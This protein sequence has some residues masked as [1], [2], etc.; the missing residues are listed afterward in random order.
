[1]GIEQL[2]DAFKGNPQPLQAKVQQ[3]QQGQPPGA[4]PPDLEEAIA[5]QKIT[6][7]RNSAQGQQAI[8]AGGA[9]RSG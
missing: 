6:E 9:L 2:V 1:M 5:L 8:Q 4:I 7:L 3:A